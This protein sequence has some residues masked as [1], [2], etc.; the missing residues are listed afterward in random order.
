MTSWDI[1]KPNFPKLKENI[2]TNVLVIGG[3]LA[4]VSTAY[5][6]ALSG[7]KVVL[8]E[9]DKIGYGATGVTTAFLTHI[10]DTGLPDLVKMFG[11]KKAKLVWQSHN[12]AIDLIEKI[13][14]EEKI[15][16]DFKRI[17]GYVF[18]GE[19]NQ[20]QSIK[21][22]ANEARKLGF[23]NITFKSKGLPF[24]N[25]GFFEAKRQAMFHPLRFLYGLVKSAEARGVKIFEKT[26]VKNIKGKF[27]AETEN[28]FK[29]AAGKVIVCTYQPFNSPRQVFMKKGMYKSYVLELEISKNFLKEGIYWDNY[30][31]YNYF[32]VDYINSRAR[33][34]LGGADHR[35]ELPMSSSKNFK[36]LTDFLK[37]TFGGKLQ[38]KI[39][40]KW[41]GPILE[42]SD[43]LAL[44]GEYKPNEF[45]ATGFS[46]NGM[47]YSLISSVLLRDLVLGKKNDWAGIYDPRRPRNLKRYGKKAIDYASELMGGAVR[48]SIKYRNS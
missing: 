3:G 26:A 46:G 13:S 42:P 21:E 12:K 28:G 11:A 20:I 41:T 48:N 30:S 6:L 31:P 1:K 35:S 44:I 4:G 32:R 15:K 33:M 39:V 7:K 34:I 29:I 27:I 38:Y 25:H 36:A 2:E 14:K 40:K 47:T 16:C 19:E 10:V 5:I 37:N 43:G 8:C 9:K 17:S 18:A 45:V 24:K 23:R 22:E